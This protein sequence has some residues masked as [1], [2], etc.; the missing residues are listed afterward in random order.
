MTDP[1]ADF[2]TR[3][4]NAVRGRKAKVS[5]PAS[6]MKVRIAEILKEEGF[7][8]DLS[9]VPDTRQGTLEI[10]LKYDDQNRSAIEGLKR[11]SRPGQRRYVRKDQLPKVRAGMGVAIVT[12]SRGLM[13]D[14][15]ARKRSLGGEVICAIW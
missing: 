8:N 2:L 11:V 1:I 14:R 5:S 7:I 10:M 6:K 15:E 9:V 12:T 4:R 13:S 3:I